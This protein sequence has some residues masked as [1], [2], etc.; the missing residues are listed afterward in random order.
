MV[1]Y[2][3]N[4]VWMSADSY[5]DFSSCVQTLLDYDEYKYNLL[6]DPAFA[7]RCATFEKRVKPTSTQDILVALRMHPSSGE[8]GMS[9]FDELV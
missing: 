1:S 8:H 9:L 6:N 4:K 3:N 5:E 7:R 2:D